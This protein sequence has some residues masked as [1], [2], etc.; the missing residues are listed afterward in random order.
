M[1]AHLCIGKQ[2]PLPVAI[3][4]QASPLQTLLMVFEWGHHLS[5]QLLQGLWE[6]PTFYV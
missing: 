3:K 6:H 5:K 2:L 4:G 1:A